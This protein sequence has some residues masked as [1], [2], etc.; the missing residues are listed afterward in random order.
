M[1][2]SKAYSAKKKLKNHLDNTRYLN[3]GFIPTEQVTKYWWR[4]INMAVFK[5]SLPPPSDIIIRKL[6]DYK[7]L[8][9]WGMCSGKTRINLCEITINENI[10]SKKLFLE[11]LIHEMV[12]QHQWYNNNGNMNHGKTFKEWEIY[13]KNKFDLII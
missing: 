11:T 5:N 7:G 9:I 12:H 13:F 1:S 2:K 6:R 4:I 10:T 3:N 8:Y